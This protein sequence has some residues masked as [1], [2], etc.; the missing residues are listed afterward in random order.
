MCLSDPSCHLE[1][2]FS[3]GLPPP[4]PQKKLARTLS[5]PGIGAPL[6]SPLHPLSPLQRHQQ[7]FDNPLYMMTPISDTFFHKETATLGTH[8]LT[9]SQLSFATPDEHL[10]YLFRG[11]EDRSIVSQGIQHR[12]LLF[13]RSMAQSVEAEILLQGEASDKHLNSYQPQDF[14]QC[15]GSQPKQV[16]DTV[17]YSLHSPKFPG[18]VLGLKVALSNITHIFSGLCVS[19]LA[20]ILQFLTK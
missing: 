6:L 17:Y 12:H 4:I 7:S 8:L 14:L 9:L 18:R 16:G 10:P 2:F 5:L 20:I 19:V 15:E 13:L 1:R 3:D 11:F